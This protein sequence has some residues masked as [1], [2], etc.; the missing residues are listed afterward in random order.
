MPHIQ[1]D[2]NLKL[3]RSIVREYFNEVDRRE[4]VKARKERKKENKQFMLEL[5]K[6]VLAAMIVASLY[7]AIRG[8]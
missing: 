8:V 2:D 7:Q 3:A 5:T 1:D 4:E 6:L